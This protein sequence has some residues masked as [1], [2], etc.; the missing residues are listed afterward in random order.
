MSQLTPEQQKKAYQIA[1]VIT[2]VTCLITAVVSIATLEI[3]YRP[4]LP[5]PEDNFVTLT[6]IGL[7]VVCVGMG[8]IGFFWYYRKHRLVQ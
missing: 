5:N 7:V 4:A 6:E 3:M 2:L 1:G 8:L